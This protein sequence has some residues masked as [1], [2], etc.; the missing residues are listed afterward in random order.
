M[1]IQMHWDDKD[2]QL[3]LQPDPRM[4][5]WPGGAKLFSVKLLWEP[6]APPSRF[7]FRGEKV[8]TRF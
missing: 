6:E 5:K 8:A 3:T 1:W 4:K 2:R 7:E